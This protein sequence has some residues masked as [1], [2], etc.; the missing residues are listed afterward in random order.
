MGQ[1]FLGILANLPN[2]ENVRELEYI[3]EPPVPASEEEEGW[4]DAIEETAGED[5]HAFDDIYAKVDSLLTT[6][7]TGLRSFTFSLPWVPHAN[8]AQKLTELHA[9]GILKQPPETS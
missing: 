5:D 9:R 4:L 1:W 7:F 3:L 6:E 8:V 2:P